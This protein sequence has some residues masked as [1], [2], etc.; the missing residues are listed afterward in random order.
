[1]T[2][3]IESFGMTEDQ[4]KTIVDRHKATRAREN[5]DYHQKKKNDPVY[6]E[7]ARARAKRHYESTSKETKRQRY[8]DNREHIACRNLYVYYKKKDNIQKFFEKHPDKVKIL[9]QSNYLPTE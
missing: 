5:R 4:I 7:K 1:M 9:Q 8:Q 3:L 2:N 6:R